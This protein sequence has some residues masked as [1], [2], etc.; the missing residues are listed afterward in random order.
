MKESFASLV[1][2]DIANRSLLKR[3]KITRSEYSRRHQEFGRKW[4]ELAFKRGYT[5]PK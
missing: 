5:V 4:E 3:G 2:S 1:K